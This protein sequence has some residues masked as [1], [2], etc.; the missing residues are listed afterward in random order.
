MEILKTAKFISFIKKGLHMPNNYALYN[1]LKNILK[2]KHTMRPNTVLQREGTLALINV[3]AAEAMCD[4]SLRR[5]AS[6]WHSIKA[7]R[8]NK[9]QISNQNNCANY[10]FQHFRIYFDV[11]LLHIRTNKTPCSLVLCPEQKPI[12]KKKKFFYIYQPLLFL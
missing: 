9:E 12:Y 1:Y 2:L 4:A 3:A 10:T 11:V 8:R 5:P 6:K 7:L